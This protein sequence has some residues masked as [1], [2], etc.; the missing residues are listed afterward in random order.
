MVLRLHV[1]IHD[2]CRLEHN[3][4]ASKRGESV[5]WVH[6]SADQWTR[7]D[8]VQRTDRHSDI[9]SGHARC[10]DYWTDPLVPI[11]DERQSDAHPHATCRFAPEYDVY[12]E[13]LGRHRFE[14]FEPDRS[15][16][17]NFR[18][19]PN[20]RL[21]TAA[22]ELNSP[23]RWRYWRRNERHGANPIQQEDRSTND[24]LVNFQSLRER[25]DLDCGDDRRG[26]R[27]T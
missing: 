9:G 7:D 10:C 19:R 1:L 15:G 22:G 12:R 14:R 8:S 25:W 18:H 11:C 2:R 13:H 27:W 3:R 17:N 5:E 21:F 23:Q 6:A 4:A 20:R 16:D 26:N 24:N